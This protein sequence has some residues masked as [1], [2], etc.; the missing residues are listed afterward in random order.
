LSN[1]VTIAAYGALHAGIDQAHYILSTLNV[2]I[3]I[4]L[5]LHEFILLKILFPYT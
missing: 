1:P 3:R 4:D 2:V 5:D